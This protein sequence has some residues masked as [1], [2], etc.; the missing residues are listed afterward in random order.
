MDGFEFEAEGLG[1]VTMSNGVLTGVVGP[2]PTTAEVAIC[3][4]SA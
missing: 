2:A 4:P 3:A 1:A